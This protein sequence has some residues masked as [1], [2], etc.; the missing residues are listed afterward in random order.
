MK[1]YFFLLIIPLVILILYYPAIFT[2]F[3]Q[4]DFFHFKVSQTDGSISQFI[5]LFNYHPFAERGIAFYRPVFREA[6]F[7]IFYFLFGLNPFPF[8]ILQF[9]ILLSNSFLVY[10]L[11]LGIFRRKNLSSLVTFF[12]SISSVHIASL[13]Y[14]AGGIQVLGATFFTLI[15]LIFWRKYLITKTFYFGLF[16]FIGAL[17]A[18]GSH[19]LSVIIPFLIVGFTIIT[20]G[21]NRALL[22]SKYFLLLFL[23]LIIHLF[24]EKTI[25][26]YSQTEQQYTIL[27]NPKTILNSYA[28]YTGWALGLPEMLID[29]VLPGFKLNPDLM[30]YWGGYYKIIFSS[31]IISIIFLISSV[32]I[33][34]IYRRKKL[35]S[36]QSLFFLCWFIGGLLPVIFL[37]F[38]KSTQYLE[39]S[40]VAFWTLI[41]LIITETYTLIRKRALLAKL[42]VSFFI[43]S[44]IIL[45]ATSIFLERTTY[46]AAQRGKFAE[47]L[48]R[49][50][51]STYPVLPKGAFLYIENDP[52]YPFIA[53]DWGSS[54]KQAAFILNNSDALR[55]VYKDPT[56]E[57]YYEDIQKPPMTKSTHIIYKI[58]AKI[59]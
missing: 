20:I 7:N 58:V 57:V 2:Y 13:F 18:L 42:Y 46:W 43:L 27:F 23:I 31:F 53:K 25:I 35:F 16:S 56:L 34:F 55:L 28:W 22:F 45:S 41:G 33:I 54:S 50:I 48:I 21:F 32:S 8:R 38:H 6:L 52:D 12:Y 26:G 4:D 51:T 9:I 40:L 24:L 1:K 47:Q 59:L 14:L 10:S 17:L 44:L 5:N 39:L 49:Q 3:S 15:S 19:E 37:P 36:V 29:F 11:I 30:K